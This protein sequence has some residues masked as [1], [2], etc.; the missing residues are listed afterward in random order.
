MILEKYQGCGN[1]FLI[2]DGTRTPVMDCAQVAALC[3]RHR[4]FGADGLI[5]AHRDP[6]S[7]ELWNQDGSRA[8]MCGNG[9]RCFVHYAYRKGWI[10]ADHTWVIGTGDGLRQAWICSTEPFICKVEAGKPD[11]NARRIT[12]QPLL[13]GLLHAP[14]LSQQQSCSFWLGVPHTVIFTA[15]PDRISDDQARSIGTHPFFSEGTNVDFVRWRENGELQVR[16]WERGVGWTLAC[17]TGACASAIAAAIFGLCPLPAQVRCPGG[18]LS[19]E[20]T[21]DQFCLLSGPSQF[22]GRVEGRDCG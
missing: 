2:A 5:I 11:F 9:L 17:G 7:M 13:P 14:F 1:D 12:Q 15:D 16:T 21:G 22:I 18:L 8:N 20:Q 4:G 10:D 3:D 19:V 6:L